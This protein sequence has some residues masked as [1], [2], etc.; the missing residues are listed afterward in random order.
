MAARIGGQRPAQDGDVGQP[1][2]GQAVGQA[3][4]GGPFQGVQAAGAAGPGRQPGPGGDRVGPVQAFGFTES[5][6]VGHNA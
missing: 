1:V 5:A 2:A 3:L 6:I 4:P